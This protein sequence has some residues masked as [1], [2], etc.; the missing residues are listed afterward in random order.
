MNKRYF[1]SLLLNW[2]S[3]IGP[4][5]MKFYV[6]SSHVKLYWTSKFGGP[7]QTVVT[8][9]VHKRLLFFGISSEMGMFEGRLIFHPEQPSSRNFILPR[10]AGAVDSVPGCGDG[11]GRSPDC[12][13]AAWHW[14]IMLVLPLTVHFWGYYGERL[15]KFCLWSFFF[16]SFLVLYT[17]S[18]SGSLICFLILNAYLYSISFAHEFTSVIVMGF[19][20]CPRPTACL[21]GPVSRI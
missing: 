7:I 15:L 5:Y 1:S 9:S 2:Q 19:L 10:S 21:S 17:N 12:H 18:R 6:S 4:K 13:P 20:T 11:D 8:I 16:F 3:S 14:L